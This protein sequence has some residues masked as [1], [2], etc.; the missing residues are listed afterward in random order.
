MQLQRQSIT[1][2]LCAGPA[3]VV[4]DEVGR[5]AEAAELAAPL[6]AGR[7]LGSFPVDVMQVPLAQLA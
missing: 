6:L 7:L 3:E 5:D 4:A 2:W 1:F